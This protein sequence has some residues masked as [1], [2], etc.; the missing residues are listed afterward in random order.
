[1]PAITP[2]TPI[3]QHMRDW[4][5]DLHRHPET[6]YEETRTAAKIAALLHDF[7]LDE[8]HTGLAQTGVVGVLH[9]NRPG[10][11]LGLRADMDALD[12]H[13]A[14]T[15]A[16]R[17]QTAGKMHACGHDGHT[18]I[19]MAACRYFDDHYDQLSGEIHAIFQHAEEKLPGGAREM[20]ATGYFDSRPVYPLT[21]PLSSA[22]GPVAASASLLWQLALAIALLAVASRLSDR[23]RDR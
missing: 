8:I 13:E 3:D 19:L 6:A 17:S 23:L 21:G 14:N 16:H 12:I 11:T 7:G 2:H 20:V 4:R 1:M 15:F 22:P 18:A 9:G 5:H 10:K